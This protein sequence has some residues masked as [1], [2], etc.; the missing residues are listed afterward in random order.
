MHYIHTK[1]IKSKKIQGRVLQA[2]LVFSIFIAGS[3]SLQGF[4]SAKGGAALPGDNKQIVTG[5]TPPC[6]FS[7]VDSGI[8]VKATTTQLADGTTETS[9]TPLTLRGQLTNCSTS[10]QAYYIELKEAL[11]GAYDS[12][13]QN[14]C[15]MGYGSGEWGAG[16]Y[17]LKTGSKKGW[18]VTTEMH[19]AP[20]TT[21]GN[22]IGT[23]TMSVRTIDRTTGALLHA[24]T[25]T[26]TV[27]Q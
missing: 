17:L 21:K 22:C 23:H 6:A 13:G 24:T 9:L 1:A 12:L 20:I 18:S 4:S 3:L 19:T 8:T 26:Y 2:L 10:F 25:A 15:V 7:S 11:V 14:A 27:T 16:D 5:T